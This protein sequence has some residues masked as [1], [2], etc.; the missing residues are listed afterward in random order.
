MIKK[1][2]KGAKGAKK[3]SPA[4]G[5]PPN[6]RSKCALIISASWGWYWW[7][8]HVQWGLPVFEPGFLFMR[9]GDLKL[10]P[11]TTATWNLRTPTATTI[12]WIMKFPVRCLWGAC[13][14]TCELCL[15]SAAGTPANSSD[16]NGKA[17]CARF[18]RPSIARSAHAWNCVNLLACSCR[19]LASA[20]TP[21]NSAAI[22]TNKDDRNWQ[23]F[24][25][26][27]VSNCLNST[28]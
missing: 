17:Q 6:S 13:W 3:I 28:L 23:T 21:A 18:Y 26:R 10:L 9:R 1:S 22:T 12:I 4:A 27:L 14:Q 15:A 5:L 16:H 19:L 20:G 7:Q 8:I 11:C 2:A 24:Q 25:S